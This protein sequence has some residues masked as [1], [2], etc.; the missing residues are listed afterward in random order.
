MQVI[1]VKSRSIEDIDHGYITDIDHGGCGQCKKNIGCSLTCKNSCGGLAKNTLGI[2]IINAWLW[3]TLL[4]RVGVTVTHR[5]RES[6]EKTVQA[7][8]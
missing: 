7:T 8:K 3:P 1:L 2:Y 4:T 5:H 6:G